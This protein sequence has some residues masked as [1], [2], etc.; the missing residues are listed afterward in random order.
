MKAGKE[1]GRKGG[2]ERTGRA[3]RKGGEERTREVE[4]KG[5]DE[6]TEVE[7]KGK[8]EKGGSGEIKRYEG[9]RQI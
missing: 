9:G 6:K 5:G 8:N 3:E 4:R 1:E 7:G 2:K